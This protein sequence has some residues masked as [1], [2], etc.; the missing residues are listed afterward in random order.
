M[1]LEN[2]AMHWRNRLF[3]I[4]PNVCTGCLS[5]GLSRLLSGQTSAVI[6]VVL[7]YLFWGN[8][9]L[10]YSIIIKEQKEGAVTEIYSS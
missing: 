7:L 1:E 4:W 8:V 3:H 9:P 10:I 6:I 2:G 5:P